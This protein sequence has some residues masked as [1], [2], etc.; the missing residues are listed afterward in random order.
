MVHEQEERTVQSGTIVY[1][2][3]FDEIYI[4]IRDIHEQLITTLNNISNN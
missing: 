1:C 4:H 2:P 3:A